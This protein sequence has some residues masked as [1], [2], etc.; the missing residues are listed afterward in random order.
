[1]G[2]KESALV[3]ILLI[4]ITLWYQRK[5]QSASLIQSF[6][7][8]ISATVI[9]ATMRYFVLGG[10]GLV[11]HVIEPLDN[12]LIQTPQPSRLLNALALL[13]KYAQLV[14]YPVPLSADYSYRQLTGPSWQTLISSPL[15]IS[16]LATVLFVLYGLYA[17]SK[18][19]GD[20]ACLPYGFLASFAVT[21]NVFFPPYYFR[22]ETLLFTLTWNCPS[23]FRPK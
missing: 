14:V 1:L 4:G 2:S 17:E 23:D 11:M 22:R 12:P 20:L 15:Q 6:A 16:F 21:S 19:V 7:G 18:V 3:Y 13:G 9:Y 5:F 8:P 10:F